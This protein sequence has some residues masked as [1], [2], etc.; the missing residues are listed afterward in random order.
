KGELVFTNERWQEIAGMSFEQALG[1]GWKKAIHPEDRKLVLDEW[2]ESILD[3]SV[4]NL[5]YRFK[6]PDGVITWVKGQSLAEKNDK[7]EIA[8][9][10]GTITDITR[11][12]KTEEALL[13][14][15]ERYRSYIE[16]TGQLGWTTNPHGEVVE[17]M[18]SWRNYTGQTYDQ[19]K[20]WGWSNALHPDDIDHTV[21]IWRKAVGEKS[22]YET[23]Y[24]LRRHDGIYRFFMACGIPVLKEDGSIR[25]W[26]G[27]C[28]DITERKKAE[29]ALRRA[30]DE[31]E[32]RVQER[33][34]ELAKTNEELEKEKNHIKVT[35]NLL[36]LFVQRISLKEYLDSVVDIIQQWSGC[37]CVGIRILDKN[38]NIPYESYVGFSQDFLKSESFL[39][40][41][42]DQCACIRV[43]TGRHE[44]QDLSALTQYGSF[45][46]NNAFAFVKGLT[47][48]DKSRFRSVC[49]ESGFESV[50][51]IP[52][53]YQKKVIGAV[54]LAD[55][56]E[57][58]V[59]VKNVKFIENLSYMIGGA[60]H[61][62]NA[63]KELKKS[64]KQLRNLTAH[65]QAV[66]E[67]E[68]T[69]IAREIH[70]EL[71]QS[72]TAL[73]IELS[74]I[75]AKYSD[76]VTLNEKTRRMLSQIDDI[77]QTVKKIITELRPGILDHI[78]ISAAVEWQAAEFQ[79]MSGIPCS[80]VIIPD[81]IIL[82]RELS[83]NI[84]RILQE[85]LTNV[86]RHAQAT[87]VDVLFEKKDGR[88]TLVIE[89][90]GKGITREQ[91][92]HSASFGITGI[93][94]RIHVMNGDIK[95]KGVPDKGTSISISI[96]VPDAK[97]LH[98]TGSL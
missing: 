77:I 94:E 66:R 96:P 46:S 30:Y 68:R 41:E 59:P 6:R 76:H 61:K 42:K 3:S 81:E 70:D 13:A 78:G 36:E 31:M 12:K 33:T 69:S 52:L 93:R 27:T 22:R 2:R 19:I 47:G 57:G 60:I 29:E 23:E 53:R 50:A 11:L 43:F 64:Q 26:V 85:I 86:M 38:G 89:D 55:E 95:I 56:R 83:T 7:G 88:V 51:V 80:V 21:K 8:G 91:I 58:M 24:R 75:K 73:K 87:S 62:F 10:V 1:E 20:G 17:D 32:D 74:W 92:S 54:H 28:V 40:T 71:G 48:A 45:Y 5:E 63:E 79:K 84:F 9:Y 37:R 35:N 4:F 14:S 39:S 15:S 34:A 97:G 44:R 65:L 98:E 72:M 25:E 90:N 67:D 49:V 82:N 18:S 16:V